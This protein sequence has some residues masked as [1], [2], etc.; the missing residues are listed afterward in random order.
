LYTFRIDVCFDVSACQ[1]SKT[2]PRKL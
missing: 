1:S 2:C